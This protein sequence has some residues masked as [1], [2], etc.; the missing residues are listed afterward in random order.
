M[1]VKLDSIISG[2]VS[3]RHRFINRLSLVKSIYQNISG[4]MVMTTHNTISLESDSGNPKCIYVV[5]ETESGNREIETLT[6]YDQKIHENTSIRRQYL[7]GTY[8]G[9]PKVQSI[10]FKQMLDELEI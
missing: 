5:N 9:I 2:T 3:A 8:N 1:T 7:K 4:Q 10:N 6:H